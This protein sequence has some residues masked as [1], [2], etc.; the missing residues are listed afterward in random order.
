MTFYVDRGLH[1]VTSQEIYDGLGQSPAGAAVADLDMGGFNIKNVL[2]IKSTTA[3]VDLLSSATGW[4]IEVPTGATVD[5]IINAATEYTFTS[6]TLDMGQNILSNFAL[7]QGITTTN[8]I[9]D[10]T[11]GWLFG[12]ATGHNYRLAVNSVN[13]ATLDTNTLDL[14]VDID[15]NGN[16]IDFDQIAAPSNPAAGTRRL[17]TDSAT[18]E[19]SVRTSG[20][21][22][23]SLEGGGG[24]NEFAD[25]VFRIYDSV[26]TTKKIA[27]EATN[28]TTANVRTI[29]MLD[30]DLV[31]LGRA[32]IQTVE[33]KSFKDNT[34]YFINA[35]DTSKTFKF[36]AS[37]IT[38]A[39]I[40]TY[41]MPNADGTIPLLGIT[42]TWTGIN[43]FNGSSTSINSATIVIGDATTDTVSIVAEV[44]ADFV[45][46]IDVTY[47]NGSA[48]KA[49]LTVNTAIVDLRGSGGAV[50]TTT[51][52]ISA[53]STEMSFNA[54]TGDH[55]TF[56]SNGSGIFRIEDDGTL[57]F[58]ESGRQH[59]IDVTA[60]SIDILSE[61]T[62]DTVKIWTGT[63][64]T[65][66]NILVQDG[67]TIFKNSTSG[68]RYELYIQY[69]NATTTGQPAIGNIGFQAEDSANVQ[70]AYA[71]IAT[72]IED[73]TSTGRDG[74]MQLVVAKND[75]TGARG[76]GQ[77][78]GV[79]IDIRSQA[80]VV[81]LGFFGATPVAKPTG[82][83]VTAAAI[84]AALVSLGLIA[85]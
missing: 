83:A 25:N 3:G 85:A 11:S 75:G 30:E 38:T 19:L 21:T 56:Y 43:S 68:S 73:D 16:Y 60:T 40:R 36:D 47:L 9:D 14:A 2:E 67:N 62:T 51:H 39:T 79:G 53:S 10:T 50:G 34:N 82:V 76:A 8:Q 57:Q 49:W 23:V 35:T 80:G 64:R 74:R 27:F 24:T 20:G 65:N 44:G 59:R 71:A 1:V 72:A 32:N 78:T 45:P 6:T 63:A 31:L 7:L 54:P 33:N 77:I 81:Q 22:T 17:F 41:T 66:E 5:I 29:T 26:D 4:D 18:G 12:V 55:F 15:M 28:I 58:M 46:D 84:H 52:R 42:N 61:N 13:K 70:S 48:S 69:S 37:A